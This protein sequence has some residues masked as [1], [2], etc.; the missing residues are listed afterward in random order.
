VEVTG[1]CLCEFVR[2][3]ATV[4]ENLVIICH[5][6]SC[7]RHSGT[8]FG[9]VVGIVDDAFTLTSGSLETHESVADSGSVRARTFCPRCGTRIYAKTVGEGTPFFGLRT[10]TV[11]QRDKLIP[12][13]QVWCRSAQ[14]WALL[15][16]LPKYDKQPTL[17]EFSALVSAN[18]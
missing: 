1:R 7:Q 12:K 16:S 10:G 11:D 9:V 8:A 14:P 5:C 15:E 6:T 4:N 18:N 2:Y 13:L 17:D 3:E